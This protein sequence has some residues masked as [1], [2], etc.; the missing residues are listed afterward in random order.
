MSFQRLRSWSVHKVPETQ[1]Y[2]TSL[3]IFFLIKFNQAQ[4][5]RYINTISATTQDLLDLHMHIIRHI[6]KNNKSSHQI[7][8][9]LIQALFSS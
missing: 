3:L 5:N 8:Q 9:K 2:C 6:M 4:I 7:K 1:K